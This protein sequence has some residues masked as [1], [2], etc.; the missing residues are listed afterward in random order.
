[1]F[2]GKTGQ[3]FVFSVVN[4]TSVPSFESLLRRTSFE[5]HVVRDLRYIH[6]SPLKVNWT[7]RGRQGERGEGSGRKCGA[8]L[9]K[10]KLMP[11][12]INGGHLP[13]ILALNP[14]YCSVVANQKH[15]QEKAVIQIFQENR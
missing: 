12:L 3:N 8:F 6:F 7:F 11:I 9:D 10:S 2:L 4:P 15:R 13:A 1:M 14:E 5:L